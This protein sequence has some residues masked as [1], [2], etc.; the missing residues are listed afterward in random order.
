MCSIEKV[1][2]HQHL[3]DGIS[4]ADESDIR[5]T[6]RVC[7][8]VNDF[9]NYRALIRHI[10]EKH[11]DISKASMHDQSRSQSSHHDS[12]ES[13]VKSGKIADIL[14]EIRKS[15]ACE[16]RNSLRHK[17]FR[18]NNEKTSDVSM[19]DEP[20]I[21]IPKPASESNRTKLSNI[22]SNRKVIERSIARTSG[23]FTSSD[24]YDREREVP[25]E[26]ALEVKTGMEGK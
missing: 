19:I 24:S 2:E 1:V 22:I 5:F 8:P 25:I 17:R 6:C 13:A 10:K 11:E 20:A 14:K 16:E 9:P 12:K 3:E 23:K 26:I 4:V 18:P 15:E 7:G 21:Q